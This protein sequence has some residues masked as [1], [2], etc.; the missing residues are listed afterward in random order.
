MKSLSIFTT[1]L[2]IASSLGAAHAQIVR[3]ESGIDYTDRDAENEY[4][5]CH[6]ADHLNDRFVFNQRD[7]DFC[8]DLIGTN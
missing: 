2:Y 1:A 5:V 4:F 6:V 3:V 8:T 7:A